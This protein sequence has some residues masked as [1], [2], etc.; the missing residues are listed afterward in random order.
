MKIKLIIKDNF[1]IFSRKHRDY[2]EQLIQLN[3]LKLR[4]CNSC[5]P[6]RIN[7]RGKE[8]DRQKLIRL[9]VDDINMHY[10]I[11]YKREGENIWL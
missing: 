9:L 4:V 2:L 1:L 3:C 10:N 8:I 7:V 5:F 11:Q 6:S